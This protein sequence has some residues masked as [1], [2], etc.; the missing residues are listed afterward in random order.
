MSAQ[1]VS[2]RGVLGEEWNQLTPSSVPGIDD[3]GIPDPGPEEDFDRIVALAAEVCR[4][5]IALV[6]LFHDDRQWLKANLGFPTE[7]TNFALEESFC[8]YVIGLA[9]D[10]LEIP[11][12]RVDARVATHPFVLGDPHICFYAGAVLRDRGGR[13]LGALCVIDRRVRR[14]TPAQRRALITLAR[15]VSVLIEM[16][17]GSADLAQ[18]RNALDEAV[19]GRVTHLERRRHGID[20]TEIERLGHEIY[21]DVVTRM[22]EGARLVELAEVICRAVDRTVPGAR[23][24]LMAVD[25]ATGLLNA[26]VAPGL[27]DRFVATMVDI[28]IRDGVGSCGTAAALRRPVVAEKISTDDRW[29]GFRHLMADEGVDACWSFPVIGPSGAVIGTFGVYQPRHRPPH[30]DEVRLIKNLAALTAIVL[31]A[32]SDEVGRDHPDALTGLLTRDGLDRVLGELVLDTEMSIVVLGIDRF[33]L[34]NRQFGLETGDMALR[35]V[36][37][38]LSALAPD[39]V[40]ARFASDQF[41][42]VM[43]APPRAGRAAAHLAASTLA[44][45]MLAIV[46][47]PF[48]AAGNELWLTASVGVARGRADRGQDVLHA[49]VAAARR[50]RRLGGDRILDA[51]RPLDEQ[52]GSSLELVGALHRA[53]SATAL[54]VHYQPKVS[55]ADGR[56]EDLEALA[57]WNRDD[58]TVVAPSE[59]IPLA[60]ELGLIGTIGEH[61]LRRAC[62][63]AAR[64]PC[65]PSGRSPGVAVN[66]SGR[67]LV[68]GRLAVVVAAALAD[69]G[70]PADRLIL[71]V[72]ETA[73]AEDLESAI[74]ALREVRATG[75]RIA[76]DDFGIGYSSLGHLSRFPID[77]L[78]VDRTFV[79]RMGLD[80]AVDAIV[81]SVV[82]LSHNLGLRC[83]AEGVEQADQLSRLAALGCDTYQGYLF[84]PAVA[85]DRVPALIAASGV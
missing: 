22:A 67:Q 39:A 41:A 78:K 5:P 43:A 3:P 23:S 50:A 2:S 19:A 82:S 40:V 56:I 61:V 28:P 10:V 84:S 75:V 69:A 74:A 16:R 34:V 68:P 63:D 42:A 51:D 31:T 62:A 17:R 7:E 30:E 6:S 47:A 57:R 8:Q 65:G 35:R 79:E 46:R 15:Q 21:A 12:A 54:E 38:R 13:V 44:E 73:L 18:A 53:V 83:V 66:I 70:L 33:G 49:A 1:R 72:T 48:D 37:R 71:E 25:G 26:V 32:R 77:E 52:P 4:T 20:R 24:S 11:D 81:R 58:G 27:S 14:L 9:D 45:G 64:W 85:N 59:F 80:P 76:I 60:E 36:A 55:V 29:D